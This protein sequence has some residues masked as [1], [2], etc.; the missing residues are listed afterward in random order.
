MC[1]SCYQPRQHGYRASPLSQKFLLLRTDSFL[2]V[3][4]VSYFLHPSPYLASQKKGTGKSLFPRI[5]VRL[6]G[7]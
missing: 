2:R 3:R 5:D 4:S 7:Y 1:G 6:L